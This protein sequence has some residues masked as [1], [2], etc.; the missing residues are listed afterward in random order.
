MNRQNKTFKSINFFSVEFLFMF[1]SVCL[2]SIFLLQYEPSNSAHLD[3]IERKSE[4]RNKEGPITAHTLICH[5]SSKLKET[6]K[7]TIVFVFYFLF[8]AYLRTM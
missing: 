3:Q 5:N 4:L 1:G 8:F 2:L 7:Q 6:G